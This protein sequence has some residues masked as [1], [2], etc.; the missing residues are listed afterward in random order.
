MPSQEEV[1][2]YATEAEFERRTAFAQYGE[3]AL[4]MMIDKGSGDPEQPD[5][6]GLTRE[7]FEAK[8]GMTKAGV[9]FAL[10]RLQM[11]LDDNNFE[12]RNKQY[13]FFIA[14]LTGKLL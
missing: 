9:N 6:G 10:I 8:Y 11:V 1:K 7:E 3:A 4:L 12:A 14:L 5:D 13:D 2:S